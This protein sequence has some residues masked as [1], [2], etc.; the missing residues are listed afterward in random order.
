[1][2]SRLHSSVALVLFSLVAAAFAEQSRLSENPVNLP[3]VGN[4]TGLQV[5]ASRVTA[6]YYKASILSW[7]PL[8]VSYPL[9]KSGPASLF[10]PTGS[11]QPIGLELNH[12]PALQLDHTYEA[13]MFYFYVKARVADPAKQPLVLWMTGTIMLACR[14]V[15]VD[16]LQP[17]NDA[18]QTVFHSRRLVKGLVPICVISCADCSCVGKKMMELTGLIRSYAEVPW[19]LFMGLNLW[20]WVRL[21]RGA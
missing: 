18:H 20:A 4:A 17:V 2:M 16:M 13:S 6:G 21:R 11:L 12:L 15:L 14:A 3:H 1:M 7:R 5:S 9:L 8:H 19:I 10:E